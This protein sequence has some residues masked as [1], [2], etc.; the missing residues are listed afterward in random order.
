MYK[1][2]NLQGIKLNWYLIFQL[3]QYFKYFPD[4]TRLQLITATKIFPGGSVELTSSGG[5]LFI[6]ET[7]HIIR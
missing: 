1:L 2:A 4:C 3:F 6:M 5:C 7:K